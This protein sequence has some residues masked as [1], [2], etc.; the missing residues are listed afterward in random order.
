MNQNIILYAAIPN[1]AEPTS[2]VGTT[3][4]TQFSYPITDNSALS[5]LGEGSPKNF[6][7]NGTLGWRFQDKHFGK[8]S[9]EFLKQNINYTFYSGNT[10]QWVQQSAIGAY[11]QYHWS[12]SLYSP[13][14]I[15]QGGYSHAPNKQ[16]STVTGYFFDNT[17]LLNFFSN[18]RRIAG[19]DAAYVSPGVSIESWPG[20]RIGADLNYDHV[21]YDTRYKQSNKS[22]GIGG[23]AH[24]D[25]K[26]G[27]NIE[28][29]LA[30]GIREPFNAYEAGISYS[31]ENLPFWAFGI[32]AIYVDG[33][34]RLPNTYNAGFTVRYV[35]SKDP[36]PSKDSKFPIQKNQAGELMEWVSRPAIYVPQVLAVPDQKIHIMTIIPTS[37][38]TPTPP[39]PPCI[40][41]V[42]T[43]SIPDEP[44]FAPDTVLIPTAGAFNTTEGVTFSISTTDPGNNTVTIDSSSGVVTIEAPGNE[45]SAEFTVTV[46][47]TNSCGSASVSFQVFVPTPS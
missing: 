35:S 23:T 20:A 1:T 33:K 31:P 45:V 10:R 7:L 42:A 12:Q 26:I 15:L 41:P 19:S 37:V 4:Y 34:D 29:N 36:S 18:E 9:A 17:G 43:G 25:Q 2:F 22:I 38:P 30:A 13:K 14:I 21:R 28:F 46:T 3:L 8:I 6:R 24:Y 16:L 27:K 11:Y 5:L 39:T 44:I 40:P 47:A 32:N